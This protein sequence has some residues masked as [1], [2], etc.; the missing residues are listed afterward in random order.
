MQIKRLYIN[1]YLCLQNFNIS[2][3][4]VDKGG[5][6][7][8][9]IGENG[10][11]KSTFIK[12]LMNIL[13]SFDYASIAEKINYNYTIE[14][15]YADRNIRI[16][17]DGR[18]YNV[19][20]D[21]QL[22]SGMIKTVKDKLN[23]DKIR[24]FP[25]RI[26]SFY[27]GNNKTFYEEIKKDDI[28][29]VKK[30]R[31][32]IQDYFKKGRKGKEILKDNL[33]KRKYIYCDESFVSIYLC[34]ILAGYYPDEKQIGKKSNKEKKQ[35]EKQI[36]QN[37]CKL[38]KIDKIVISLNIEFF[39][40]F[41]SELRSYEL[42]RLEREWKYREEE[43]QR[44][45]SEMDRHGY[46]RDT[47]EFEWKYRK[48]KRAYQEYKHKRIEYQL[49]YF[50]DV[51]ISFI[52]YL[53]NKLVPAF[54]NCVITPKN[55]KEVLVEI[56]NIED[57]EVEPN[58]LLD[59]LEKIKILYKAEYLVYVRAED[60]DESIKT[61]N[62]SEGQRQLIKILGMLSVC[63]KE[64]S[65]V[66]MDEPDAYMNPLWK[67]N[68]KKMIDEILEPKEKTNEPINTQ[69]IITTHDPLVINGVSKDCIRI[70][71]RV[72]GCTKIRYPDADT[73]GMGI[74]GLL[75]SEY[76]GMP[77]VLDSE[78]REKVNEK[79][80]LLVERKEKGKLTEAK[81]KRLD[82]LTEE[83]ENMTFSR[84]MPTDKYYDDFVLA[85]H[86][87]YGKEINV[88][89]TKEEIAERNAKAEEILREI[90]KR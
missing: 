53:E 49:R 38:S 28:Q 65:L 86:K 31:R 33:P 19:D 11:G 57:F 59:V 26:I 68:I 88:K 39:D 45:K 60:K 78:T 79:H 10:S 7:T 71:E 54:E 1:D 9:F 41:D 37:E 12:S 74:D 87:I 89:L 64:D 75:Q 21:G 27:S 44:Y 51:L 18:L 67:Y 72:E 76:Y 17:K 85:M 6:S 14:Y 35:N 2:L 58:S 15:K 40:S 30:C 42:D 56:Y 90:L 80:N 69:A 83:L 55:S 81:E 77:S 23:K 73:E 20:V 43:W 34:A 8:V 32:I 48:Y 63:K 13:M 22:Y 82:E 84:N 47:I 66:L 70:F 25:Q 4:I 5:S 50:K 52:E 16:E 36:I 62:L 3:K 61:A 29:Y 46:G 24:I